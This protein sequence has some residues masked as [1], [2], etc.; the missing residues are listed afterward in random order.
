MMSSVFQPVQKWYDEV[1]KPGYRGYPE[2]FRF[3]SGTGH[4]TQ[5]VW[6]DTE[7]LGCGMVYFRDGRGYKRVVICNYAVAGNMRGRL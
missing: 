6:A 7:E 2:S 5:V 4:Y 1:S 3:S